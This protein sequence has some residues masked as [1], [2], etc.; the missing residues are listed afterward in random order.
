MDL[1][2]LKRK[3][4]EIA[5]QL[6]EELGHTTSC[7]NDALV[8]R[9]AHTKPSF[10]QSFSV[11]T[12]MLKHTHTELAVFVLHD[13]CVPEGGGSRGLWNQDAFSFWAPPPPLKL[14]TFSPR[15]F[16]QPPHLHVPRLPVSHRTWEHSE[17]AGSSVFPKGP[18]ACQVFQI[19]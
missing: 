6:S 4:L 3:L 15:W 10:D 19:C 7:V 9:G 1:Y 18:L 14:Q 8:P 12:L 17:R 2:K 11:H 5:W 16:F 13:D